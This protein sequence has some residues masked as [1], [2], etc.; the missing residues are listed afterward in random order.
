MKD[1]ALLVLNIPPSMQRS[2]WARRCR[3]GTQSRSAHP[4]TEQHQSS[5]RVGAFLSYQRSS[6]PGKNTYLLV[7][8]PFTGNTK[9]IISR[10]IITIQCKWV[11][12]LFLDCL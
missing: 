5:H 11:L 10:R 7:N 1:G 9:N 2:R 4:R 6:R 12:L 8:T 3:P